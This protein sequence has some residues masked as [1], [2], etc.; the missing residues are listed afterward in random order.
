VKKE[1][2]SPRW[3]SVVLDSEGLWAVAR[4]DSEDAQAMLQASNRNGV[5]VLVSAAVLTEI[6][7]GDARDTRANQ[8][9][10]R[11]E[12]VPV[13]ESLARSAAKLKRAAGMAGVAATIDAVVVATSEA[14][15]GGIIL[16]SDPKDIR[17]LADCVSDRRIRPVRIS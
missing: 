9:L 13:T 11:V 14:A 12:V 17:A 1:M 5:P 7:F 10:K 6:F 3:P 15:G 16:T 2:P 4:G 8:T